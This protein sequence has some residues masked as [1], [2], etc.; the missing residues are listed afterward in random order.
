[1][2]YDSPQMR[3]VP[4]LSVALALVACGKRDDDKPAAKPTPAP[5]PTPNPAPVAA[6]KEGIVPTITSALKL[7][8]EW[9]EP[10]WSKRAFR[11][12]FAFDSGEQARPFSEVR[13]LHDARNLYVGL[14]A[15]DE[16]IQSSEYFEVKIG[17]L[18]FRA[19]ATGK[20]EPTI[21]GANAG[22]DRD[23]TLDDPS[24]DDEEWVLEIAIPLAKLGFAP[25]KQQPV[26]FARCDTPK[27]NV[28]RCGSWSGSVALE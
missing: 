26:R 25:A 11:R 7:D 16:N 2:A 13:L 9:D 28:K 18:A 23:G 14:Y 12:V 20:L 5:T 21:D 4:I 27:D 15:A 8:G 22:V 6:P 1:V 17:E 3:V 10:E 19:F 24:N